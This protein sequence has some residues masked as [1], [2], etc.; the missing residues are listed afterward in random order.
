MGAGFEGIPEGTL[1]VF[2]LL[3]EG[4]K[5]EG[6]RILFKLLFLYSGPYPLYNP[7][8]IS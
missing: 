8:L 7:V 2:A 4:K 6:E 3:I 5:L 1:E